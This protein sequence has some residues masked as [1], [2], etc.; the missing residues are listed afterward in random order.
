MTN[1]IGATVVIPGGSSAGTYPLDP[2]TIT[3]LTLDKINLQTLIP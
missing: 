2:A 1:V 3:A